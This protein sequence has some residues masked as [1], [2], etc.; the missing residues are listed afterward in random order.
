M[1][2]DFTQLEL[3]FNNSPASDNGMPTVSVEKFAETAY[4]DYSMYVILDRALPHVSDGLKPVQ[5]RIVYAMSEL[6]LSANAKHKKSARTVGDVI[7]KFHPHGDAAAYE[8]MVLMAQPFSYRY[9]I[10]DGQGNW[11][12]PDDPKSFAAMRYTECRLTPYAQVLLSEISKGTVDWNPNFDSTLEEPER[13]PAQLPNILLNGASGVAVGMATDIPPHNISEVADACVELLR[14]PTASIEELCGIV[15]GPDFPTAAEIITPRSELRSIY[16]TGNGT[17]RTRAVWEKSG[18]AIVISALPYQVSGAK[19]MEQIAVQMIAKKLP[20]IVDLRDEGDET[21][22]TRLVLELR[23]NRVDCDALMSHLFATT[24]LER[25]YRFNLNVIGLH[26]LPKVFNLKQILTE[27]L[28][29]RRKT[30]IKRIN[31]R[32]QQVTDRLHILA[33]LLIVYLH[34]DEVIRIIREE[35]DPKSSLMENY[36]LSDRQVEAILDIRLRQ[37]A[38]LEEIKINEELDRLNEEQSELQSTLD[39]KRRLKS[40]MISEIQAAAEKFNDER[41]SPIVDDSNSAKA[42]SSEDLTPVEP[43]TVVLSQSGWIR[44][45]KGHEIDPKTLNYREGDN[46][47]QSVKGHSNNHLIC[48]DQTGRMYTIPAYRLPSARS[49]GEPLTTMINPASSIEFAGFVLGNEEDYCLLATTEGKGFVCQFKDAITKTRSGKAVLAVRKNHAPLPCQTIGS[50]DDSVA[51]T[52]TTGRLLIYSINQLPVQSKGQGVQLI[53]I[54]PQARKEG[55]SVRA[56]SIV[57]EKQL[58][59]IHSG[60]RI[61]KIKRSERELFEGTRTQRG[62]L[63]PKGF[64]SVDYVEVVD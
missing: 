59:I 12:S 28:D 27:W 39:S 22:P 55:E 50:Q 58:L 64:R 42:F 52:T 62:K 57:S 7:G 15:Q 60:K 10:I 47:L 24:N 30:I 21:N 38:K 40:L 26:D 34:I 32:L 4:L 1:P 63:L 53:G 44:S 20:M 36:P 3:T 31:A 2:P 11:G 23:S 9:P 13:L 43:V 29:F 54:P 35:D 18:G 6:G 14:H 61:R 49:Y 51:I 46:Y 5:R 41:R 48:M 56:V 16:E 19:V 8:A 33:G 45:A 37:L 17:I 25:T